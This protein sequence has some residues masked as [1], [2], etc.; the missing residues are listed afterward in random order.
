MDAIPARALTMHS[1]RWHPYLRLARVSNLPTVWTNVLAGLVVARADFRWLDYL[2]LTCG[3]SLLYTAGMFLNDVFDS[4]W[5]AARRPDRPI[6]AGDV[7]RARALAVGA[8]LMGGGVLTIGILRPGGSA[9]A[10]AAALA[11]AIVYYDYRHK[12][13]AFGP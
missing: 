5:D 4:E 3:V 10:W 13:D 11:A 1:S 9:L 12:R 7:T 2:L 8:I 6:P